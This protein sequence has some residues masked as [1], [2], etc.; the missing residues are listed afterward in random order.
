MSVLIG[1]TL[2]VYINN[3][4]VNRIMCIPNLSLIQ[5]TIVTIT[6]VMQLEVEIGYILIVFLILPRLRK[7]CSILNMLFSK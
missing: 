1:I 6:D 4:Q 7:E 5:D 3:V 2:N